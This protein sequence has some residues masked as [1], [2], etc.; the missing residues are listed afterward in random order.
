MRPRT[1]KD[2]ANP[3]FL[4]SFVSWVQDQSVGSLSSCDLGAPKLKFT[5]KVGFQPLF[6]T[7][8]PVWLNQNNSAQMLRNLT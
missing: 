4:E 1:Q 3:W 6:H 7:M 2:P 8:Q 5:Q